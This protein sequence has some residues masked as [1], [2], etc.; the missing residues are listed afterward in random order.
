MHSDIGQLSSPHSFSVLCLLVVL[1]SLVPFDDW[2]LFVTCNIS[3]YNSELQLF[4]RATTGHDLY[5]LAKV[6]L[7][8]TEAGM[9]MFSHS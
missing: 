7:I 2:F 8:M 6:V 3:S 5:G 4:L 9:P 1:L